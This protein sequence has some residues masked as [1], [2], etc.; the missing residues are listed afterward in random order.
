[1]SKPT[2]G[3]WHAER[4]GDRWGVYK[5]DKPGLGS[6]LVG[7][8][9]ISKPGYSHPRDAADARLIAAAPDLF[10]ACEALANIIVL[11]PLNAATLIAARAALA[12]AGAP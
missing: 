9:E 10:A 6:I 7:W 5:E 12:K 8:V 4:V 3:P 11:T 2:P 1:M